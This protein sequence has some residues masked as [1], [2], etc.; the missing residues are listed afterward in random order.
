VIWT[1]FL[2]LCVAGAVAMILRIVL[3]GR[4]PSWLEAVLG[5][6]LPLLTGL[7]LGFVT[8]SWMLAIALTWLW[9]A[10]VG[11]LLV[12]HYTRQGRLAHVGL[13]A[14]GFGLTWSTLLGWGIW[15]DLTDP[16][17]SGSEMAYTFFGIGLAI[18][19]G[20]LVTVALALATRRQTV[21]E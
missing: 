1:I 6:S 18:L 21:G 19:S 10:V 8:L 5:G 13:L 15:T 7:L 2:V 17:V 20:G 14:M 11:G 9:S 3:A 4:G 12:I 16:A